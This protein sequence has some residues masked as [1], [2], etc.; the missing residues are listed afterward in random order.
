LRVLICSVAA[1]CFGERIRTPSRTATTAC[2]RGWQALSLV[3]FG[4][5]GCTAALTWRRLGLR[6]RF[7]NGQEQRETARGDE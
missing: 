3:L 5:Q 6:A 4:G 1:C 7:L 2:F